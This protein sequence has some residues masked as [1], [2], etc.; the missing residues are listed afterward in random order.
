V[1]VKS[2]STN[3]KDNVNKDIKIPKTKRQKLKL[4]HEKLMIII[5]AL[6]VILLVIL[7]IVPKNNK[8][9][10]KEKNKEETKNEI[11]EE[12]LSVYDEASKSRVYA[13]MIPNDGEAKKRQHGIMQTTKTNIERSGFI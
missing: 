7:L 4:K 2:K 13:V 3:K 12:K 6:L 5:A 11:K 10:N 1:K 8:K 9:E